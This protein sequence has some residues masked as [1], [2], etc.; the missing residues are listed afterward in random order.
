MC[1]NAPRVGSRSF[2]RP[3]HHA[4]SGEERRS[5]LGGPVA[6]GDTGPADRYRHQAPTGSLSEIETPEDIRQKPR[7]C[8]RDSKDQP[9][10]FSKTRT[11]EEVDTQEHQANNSERFRRQQRLDMQPEE[12]QLVG[13]RVA[14]RQGEHEG[15]RDKDEH[16]ESS[17]AWTGTAAAATPPRSRRPGVA[18][19]V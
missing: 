11:A 16:E 12:V 1:G 4:S 10:S 13:P 14:N 7:C 5:D 6:R 9:A 18:D 2:P 8:Q 15:R 19:T 17:W 3:G